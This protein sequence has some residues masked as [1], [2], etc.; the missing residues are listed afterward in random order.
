MECEKSCPLLTEKT[1]KEENGP[2]EDQEKLQAK[3]TVWVLKTQL[4]S[5]LRGAYWF[6][7]GFDLLHK[8]WGMTY[9][10]GICEAGR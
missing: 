2:W 9:S 6:Y 8:T 10:V 4:L 1:S 5:Y 3:N 7:Y